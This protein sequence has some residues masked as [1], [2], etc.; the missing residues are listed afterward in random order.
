[1]NRYLKSLVTLLL[2]AGP[3]L[4]HAAESGHGG[5]GGGLLQSLGIEPKGI[6]V[7]I[8]GFVILFFLLRKFLFGPLQ[9]AMAARRTEIQGTY[10]RLEEQQNALS[11]R[12]TELEQHLAEIEAERRNRIQEAANEGQALREQILAE[13]H[14]QSETIMEQG[15]RRLQIEQEQAM[16]TLRTEMADVAVRAA[17]QLIGENMNDDRHRRLVS[18]FI[19]KV[20]S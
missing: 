20:G 10:N 4:A 6:V 5:G 1:M 14:R 15:R 12:Q 2:V 16:A 18:E 13:A 17:G 8:C 7:Q 11:R 9:G 19:T 3:Q